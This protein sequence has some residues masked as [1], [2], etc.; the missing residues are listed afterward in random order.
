MYWI[1]NIDFKK[2]YAKE[3]QPHL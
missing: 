1:R 2:G 3:A